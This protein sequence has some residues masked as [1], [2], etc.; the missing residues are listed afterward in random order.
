MHSPAP[1]GQRRIIAGIKRLLVNFVCAFVPSKKY[2]ELV[3]YYSLRYRVHLG[4]P[5]LPVKKRLQPINVAFGFDGRFARQTAVAIASLL[6]NSKNRCAYNIHCVVD[7]SVTREFKEACTAMV[8]EMAPGSTLVFL[9]ANRDFD[10]CPTGNLPIYPVA[11]YFRL[12]LPNLL[13]ELGE[14]IYADADVI[15]CRDLIELADLDLGDHLLAGVRERADGYINSGLTVMN[16]D[17]LRQEKIYEAWTKEARLKDY[18]YPDQDILNITCRGRILYLPVKYNFFHSMYHN[19]YRRGGI[20]P[21]DHHELKYAVV[22]VHYASCSPKPWL[23]K[24]FYLSK[25]WWEYA[26]LTP[27]YEELLAELKS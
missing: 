5:S 21:R 6:A 22:M 25:L 11:V 16:L 3:R 9:E 7:D 15:F 14:I 4:H 20:T 8:R 26:R 24:R 17:R 27:F 12:M 2:R 1:Y 13:P 19:F 10:H 18:R 23:E